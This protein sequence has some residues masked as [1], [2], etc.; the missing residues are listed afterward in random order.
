MNTEL[1]II[2]V[3]YNGLDDTCSLIDTITFNDQLEVIVVDN[4]STVDEAAVISQRYPHVKAIRSERNLGFAGG[5][6]L[7]IKAATCF[8]STTTHCL[9]LSTS[10]RSSIGWNHRQVSRSSVLKFAL[11]GI[12]SPYSIRATPHSHASPCATSPSASVNRTMGNMM[13]P[14]LRPMPTVLR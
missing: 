5:N 11:P 12:R 6:N 14:T 8:S 2:T 4:G 13:L 1:S 3:N 7:G 9:S 10:S